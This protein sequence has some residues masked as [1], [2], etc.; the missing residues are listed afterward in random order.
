MK[1][2]LSSPLK[3]L[4]RSPAKEG[5]H[6][7]PGDPAPAG[8]DLVS[9][10][11]VPILTLLSS[12]THRRYH[13]GTFMLYSDLNGDGN[14]ADREWREVY[15]ILTGNQLAYWDAAS[16]ARF[17]DSPE[18]LFQTSSKPNYLNFTDAV[19]NAMKVL[20]AAKLQMENVLVVLTTLK[21]RYILQFKKLAHLQEWTVALRLARFEYLALQEAY[22][23]AL[24]SARGLRLSDI[25]TI[26]APKRFN[27]EDW[28]KIRY[29][30]GM[31]WKRC[32]AVIEPSQTKKKLFIPGR[33]LLFES[34][35]TKKKG[36]VGIITS[37]TLVSAVYP[38][39]PL[40]IDKSTIMQLEGSVNFK[41]R[42]VK[43]SKK[44]EANSQETSLFLM[45]EQHSSVPG[46]DTLIRFLIPLY[47]AFGLYGRPQR[48]NAD[49]T[50]PDSLVFGLPTLPHVHYLNLDDLQGVSSDQ[51][52]LSLDA[53]AWKQSIKSVLLRKMAHGYDG[54]GSSR[55]FS[56][57]VNSL[58]SP[59]LVGADSPRVASAST[60]NTRQ[61]DLSPPP[62]EGS[63][64]QL[65]TS[66]LKATQPGPINRNV[67]NLEVQTSNGARDSIQLADIYH[68]YS[69]IETPSDRYDDRNKILNG[70][71]EEIDEEVLPSLMRRKSLMNGPYPTSE[72]HLIDSESDI[73]ELDEEEVVAEGNIMSS[74]PARKVG[75]KHG[76]LAVPQTYDQRNLSYSSVQSP[77]TQYNEFNQ[78]FTKS[79]E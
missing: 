61:D 66:T 22:T 65:P 5:P 51:Q 42:S 49:R 3:S 29:G 74:S 44:D 6:S 64:E 63:R 56:G 71:A 19:F 36:L 35:N 79:V 52:F 25:R 37:A 38:Q 2:L 39:L 15:G 8:P 70:S 28:V 11:L 45:P 59:R 20:P 47:D 32:Y 9:P 75:E 14:P 58:N 13:E 10:E 30:S 17:K 4:P 33:V 34:E 54:C 43:P 18:Q 23:G 62:S 41:P 26:L 46:F 16:L 12:Q 57:A 76:M 40:F 55:G 27:H 69:T 31:A 50:D 60:T 78:Q 7:D 53:R 24:L 73:A 68:K 48:L 21:N 77:L 67:N 72:K 1:F